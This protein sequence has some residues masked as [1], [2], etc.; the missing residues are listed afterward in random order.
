MHAK[1]LGGK[2]LEFTATRT[3]ACVES[4]NRDAWRRGIR[5]NT[6]DLRISRSHARRSNAWGMARRVEEARRLQRLRNGLD[7]HVTRRR[8][9]ANLFAYVGPRKPRREQLLDL[10]PRLA[11]TRLE[12]L[13][14]VRFV[15]ERCE[16]T[17]RT[18]VQLA[19]SDALE[20]FG[21]SS[22]HARRRYPPARAAFAHAREDHS[23]HL[24][25]PR[26]MYHRAT[27]GAELRRCLWATVHRR[28]VNAA[29]RA[30]VQTVKCVTD[31]P[32]C[33]DACLNSV[34][35]FP[36]APAHDSSHFLTKQGQFDSE[37]SH[38]SPHTGA[39]PV[40]GEVGVP[41][42]GAAG[43]ARLAGFASERAVDTVAVEQT[44]LRV[45]GWQR[46]ASTTVV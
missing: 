39:S 43:C 34:S 9:P 12:Q 18:Q 13:R 7:L 28:R 15:Q 37:R 42:G 10:P 38:P 14:R 22:T 30:T 11:C 32:T 44:F 5:R 31:L 20:C 4:S 41:P 1:A 3:R 6:G 23:E 27:V 19:A 21:E 16:R 24:Q 29:R 8:Q 36:S 25:R 26:E 17:Q 40:C 35:A 2:R 46:D 45:F 33:A